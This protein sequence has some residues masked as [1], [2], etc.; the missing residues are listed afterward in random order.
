[1]FIAVHVL[2]AS[3]GRIAFIVMPLMYL[4]NNAWEAYHRHCINPVGYHHMPACQH[5][6]WAVLAHMHSNKHILF[7]YIHLDGV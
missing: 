5:T 4:Y 6:V 7:K 1:M 2:C 3:H